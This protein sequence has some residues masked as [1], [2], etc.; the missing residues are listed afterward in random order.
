MFGYAFA[1]AFALGQLLAQ[2]DH[3]SGKQLVGAIRQR[4][5]E[6]HWRVRQRGCD[7]LQ[8][9]RKLALYARD[10]VR[11]QVAMPRHYHHEGRTGR[12]EERKLGWQVVQPRWYKPVSSNRRCQ[13]CTSAISNPTRAARWLCNCGSGALSSMAVSS[14]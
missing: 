3:F 8:C 13:S 2:C 4:G 6:M 5:Q 12:T 10:I 7:Q 1:F 14:Q 9:A 11:M